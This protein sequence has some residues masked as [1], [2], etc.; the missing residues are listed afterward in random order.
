M[1]RSR[2]R[3]KISHNPKKLR[4]NQDRILGK[5]L[6]SG[7]VRPTQELAKFVTETSNKVPELKIYNNVINDPLHRNKWQKTID[8]ELWNLD[9]YQTWCYITLL[10][11]CK[12]IGCE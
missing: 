4:S 10:S 8:E 1:N 3:V 2:M 6:L 5:N 12:L 9:T 7:I 11:N